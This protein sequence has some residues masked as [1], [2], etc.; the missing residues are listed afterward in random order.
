MKKYFVL[1][2]MLATCAAAHAQDGLDSRV[3]ISKCKE[4]LPVESMKKSEYDYEAVHADPTKTEAEK[5]K[6][7]KEAVKKVCTK[8]CEGP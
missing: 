8:I 5:K 6:S 4:I 1:L 3:C 7:D 2:A